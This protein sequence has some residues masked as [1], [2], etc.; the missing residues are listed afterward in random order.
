MKKILG[1]IGVIVVLLMACSNPGGNP[2]PDNT[3]T[4]VD[5]ALV[6]IIVLQDNTVIVIYRNGTG[7]VGDHPC[8]FNGKNGELSVIDTITG[9]AI[10]VRTR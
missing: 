1:F 2:K 4:V 9:E 5:E 8:T 3:G 6:G 7:S 10:V